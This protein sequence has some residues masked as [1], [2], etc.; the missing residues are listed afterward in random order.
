MDRRRFLYDLGVFSGGLALACGGLGRRAEVLADTG[1]LSRFRAA[2]YGELSPVKPVN[3]DTAYLALPAG[4]C[5]TVIGKTGDKMSDGRPTPAKH[6][7]M[8]TFKVGGELRVVRNHE[9]H[10]DKVP[11]TGLRD[12]RGESLRRNGRRRHDDDGHRSEDAPRRSRLWQSVGHDD[13]LCRRSDAL[14]QL[15]LV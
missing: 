12:R 10:N 2:G 13:Q 14:G 9:V 3:G 11:R 4:F 6:D 7:G 15:D 5:Y 1:D 8:A